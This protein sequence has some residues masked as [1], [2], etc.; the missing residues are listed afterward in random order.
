MRVEPGYVRT[1][2]LGLVD[3]VEVWE[4]MK[5]FNASRNAYTPDELWWLEHYP[6]Y[7]RGMSCRDSTLEPTDIPIVAS[8][9]GGQLTYHGPG[10]LVG[11]ALIDIKR[12]G[13]GV[14]WLVTLLEQAVIELLECYQI[15]GVRRPGAPGVYVQGKKIAALGLRVRRGSSYHGLSVNVDMDLQPFLNINPCGY[16]DLAVT[17]L[18][19]LGVTDSVDEVRAWLAERVATL[20]HRPA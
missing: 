14:K 19:D 12:R 17:Q 20:L 6:V 18:K 11:Y 1:L 4:R 7:T 3:Y 13:K 9:R 16:K 5:A 8:D 10:Q 2:D 15:R